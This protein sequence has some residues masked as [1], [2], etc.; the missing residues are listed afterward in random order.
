MAETVLSP[1]S[2]GVPVRST[3]ASTGERKQELARTLEGKLAQGY[4]IESRDETSA[5]LSIKGR[6]RWFGLAHGAGARY[7]VTIDERGRASSRRL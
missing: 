1:P 6:S 4:R 2:N 3:R 7:E 5:V